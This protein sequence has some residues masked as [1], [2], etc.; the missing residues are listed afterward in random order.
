IEW[1]FE[2]AP[3]EVKTIGYRKGKEVCSHILRTAGPPRRI[4]LRPDK[5][6]LAA[7]DIAHVE[8]A[9]TDE[10]GVLCPNEER[11]VEFALAGDGIILGSCSPDIRGHWG[12]ALP[13][14]ITSGGKALVIIRAGAGTGTLKFSAYSGTLLPAFL[15]RAVI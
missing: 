3:G 13:K 8:V 4:L 11:L 7:G 14:T 10:T 15:E 1:T 12:Y 5:D 6:V 2:Y 9:I